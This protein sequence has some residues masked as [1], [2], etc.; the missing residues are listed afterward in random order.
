[1]I[2]EVHGTITTTP[3]RE[4]ANAISQMTGYKPSTVYQMLTVDRFNG[5]RL[6]YRFNTPKVSAI[7]FTR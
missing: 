7:A 6:G 5:S 1:M 4:V 3:R 2:V